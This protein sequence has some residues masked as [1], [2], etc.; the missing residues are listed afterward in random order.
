VRRWLLGIGLV[1]A[2][3]GPAAVPAAASAAPPS[4]YQQVL[5]V[6]QSQG[7]VPACQFSGAELSEALNGVDTYG[8]QYFADFTQAVQAALSARAAGAC[9]G[10]ATASARA[11]GEAQPPAHF[12]P[13][14]AATS[15]GFPAPLAVL[16]GLALAAGLLGAGAWVVRRRVHR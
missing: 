5:S 8:Q 1:V 15:A 12:G 9:T 10:S 7:T 11:P 4:A 2:S 16:A 14:T 13:V 3:V 6:Y